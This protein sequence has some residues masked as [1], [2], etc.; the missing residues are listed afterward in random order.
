MNTKSDHRMSAA[1]S[2]RRERSEGG[3]TMIETLMALLV[4]LIIMAGVMQSLL[5]LSRTQTMV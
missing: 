1:A 2:R 3:F 4:T 5:Q